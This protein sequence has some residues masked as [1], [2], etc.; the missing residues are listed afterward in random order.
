MNAKEKKKIS[1]NVVVIKMN[2]HKVP[3]FREVRGEDYIFFGKNNDYP[4]YLLKL[5]DRSAKHNAIINK[6]SFYIFGGGSLTCG[7]FKVNENCEKLNDELKKL[8]LDYKLFG[9]LD[10]K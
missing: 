4:E 3:Q 6:K 7:D 5:Y 10:V 9:E 8:K 1:D 2:E